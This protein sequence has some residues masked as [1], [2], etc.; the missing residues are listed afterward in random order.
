MVPWHISWGNL[1]HIWTATAHPGGPQHMGGGVN[2]ST[3]GWLWHTWTAL[4]PHLGG[5]L[6]HLDEAQTPLWC[7]SIALGT[8]LAPLGGAA[9]VT[10]NG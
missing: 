10:P 4:T 1:F 9:V 5:P 8:Y 6:P 3:S 7:H 2:F